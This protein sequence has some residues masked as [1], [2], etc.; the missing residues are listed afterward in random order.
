MSK[1][2]IFDGDL[3]GGQAVTHTGKVIIKGDICPDCSITASEDIEVHGSVV[4]SVLTSMNGRIEIKKDC[5]DSNIK[6]FD[7]V[8]IGSPENKEENNNIV[9]KSIICSDFIIR[10]NAV[11]P[12]PLATE[13][14]VTSLFIRSIP[15]KILELTKK[16]K[17]GYTELAQF[18][19]VI[20]VIQTLGEKV[21][22]L[23]EE[24]RQ[25]LILQAR[26][27]R[28]KQDLQK[29]L[30]EKQDF[31]QKIIKSTGDN[32]QPKIFING[33][34]PFGTKIVIENKSLILNKSESCLQ[35]YNKHGIH[36]SP[37]T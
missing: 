6:G 33:E 13:L 3:A 29:K 17:E 23:P 18:K 37:I 36:S 1:D 30:I 32:I 28:E 4:N 26:A 34:I 11:K 2:L 10:I 35:F 25:K 12:N 15:R 5:T 16:I 20:E 22:Q 24:Q 7:E 21:N 14:E 8:I 27:C 19:R 31:M 9:F